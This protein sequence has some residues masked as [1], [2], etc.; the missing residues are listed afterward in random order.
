MFPS[1]SGNFKPNREEINL[2]RE[3]KVNTLESER[4]I[5]IIE[6]TTEKLSFL[7]R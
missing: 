5:S 7:D 1:Q 2:I 3:D 4:I 6:D